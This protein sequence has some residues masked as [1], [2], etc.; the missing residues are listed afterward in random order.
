MKPLLDQNLSRRWIGILAAE[1]PETEHVLLLEMAKVDDIDIWDFAVSNG[2][3]IVSKDK[4][5]YQRSVAMGHPPKPPEWI[6]GGRNIAMNHLEPFTDPIY[7]FA[8]V[9][10]EAVGEGFVVVQDEEHLAR[11]LNF[12]LQSSRKLS[13]R[14]FHPFS[15]FAA[16]AGGRLAGFK[17]GDEFSGCVG[18][19]VIRSERFRKAGKTTLG[20]DEGLDV[21]FLIRK[22]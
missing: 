1:Y 2:Y 4:D 17:E 10:D 12:K 6:S 14:G 8:E 11:T 20:E 22:T 9:L 16:A 18:S 3:A 19:G 5:F 21:L 7:K 15:L 13:G